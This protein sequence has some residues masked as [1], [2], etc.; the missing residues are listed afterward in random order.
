MAVLNEQESRVGARRSV[1]SHRLFSRTA[2][3]E[4]CGGRIVLYMTKDRRYKDKERIGYRCT[5][6]CRGSYI[7]ENRMR[8]ALLAA[9]DWLSS[10]AHREQIIAA[11]PDR[12]RELQSEI[13]R[14][15]QAL[16]DVQRQRDKINHAYI[17]LGTLKDSEYQALMTDAKARE[18]AINKALAKIMTSFQDAQH[19]AQLEQRLIDISQRGHEIMQGDPAVANTWIR[20]HFTLY[21]SDNRISRIEY[22]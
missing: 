21:I 11:I 18:S 6:R 10:Q 19:R 12:T 8:E 15:N 3:C 14:L 2:F 22:K 9:I 1:N 16:R 7:Y 17:T 20:Q 13:D 4:K 5:N